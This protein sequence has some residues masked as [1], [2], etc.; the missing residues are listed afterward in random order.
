MSARRPAYPH[1]V[2]QSSPALPNT[3]SACMLEILCEVPLEPGALD[4][5]PEARIHHLPAHDHGWDLP[6]EML[7]GPEILLCKL[8]PRNLDALT[9]L[10]LIQISTVGY[11]HLR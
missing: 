8:P 11:E 9:R 2:L 7:P 3:R 4:G 1:E 5:L 6:A 10:K